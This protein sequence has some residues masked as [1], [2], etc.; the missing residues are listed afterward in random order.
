MEYKT[1]YSKQNNWDKLDLFNTD[2]YKKPPIPI[3]G[4]RGFIKARLI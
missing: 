1:N 3:N 2:K 4:T